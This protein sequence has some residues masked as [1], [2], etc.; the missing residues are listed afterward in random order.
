MTTTTT[1]GVYGV[2]V[3]VLLVLLWLWV[4]CH[5]SDRR[6]RHMGLDIGVRVRVGI[7]VAWRD[8]PVIRAL[9]ERHVLPTCTEDAFFT[10]VVIDSDEEEEAPPELGERQSVVLE[11]ISRTLER[12]FPVLLDT[13]NRRFQIVL[14]WATFD[15]YKGS[16]RDEPDGRNFPFT[17]ALYVLG[18]LGIDPAAANIFYEETFMM[19]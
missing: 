19:G 11:E 10:E 7:Q 16:N 12:R 13:E 6:R 8:S 14:D 2:V 4:Y 9:M 15:H 1:G 5:S 3:A 18:K 17:H